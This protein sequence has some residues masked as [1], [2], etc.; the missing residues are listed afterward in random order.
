M[1]H[2]RQLGDTEWWMVADFQLRCSDSGISPI[3]GQA[4]VASVAWPVYTKS[5]PSLDMLSQIS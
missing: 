5:H 4:L 2:H 1:L 3:F